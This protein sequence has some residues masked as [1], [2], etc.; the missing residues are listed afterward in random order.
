M[1]EVPA[2]L[3]GQGEHYVLEVAGDSMVEAGI[4][5][6]DSVIIQRCD[7]VDNGEVAVALID[8]QE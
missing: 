1:V 6:G 4:F 8:G 3:L 5:D 7:T 2:A